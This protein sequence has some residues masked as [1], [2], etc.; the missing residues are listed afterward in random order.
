MMRLKDIFGRTL[1][2]AFSF[3]K[4]TESTS[5]QNSTEF[6]TDLVA[7]LRAR[8]DKLGL[9]KRA[10]LFFVKKIEVPNSTHLTVECDR[11]NE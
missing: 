5:P 9:S 7:Q 10:G 1:K 11:A 8:F 4:C 6:T 2:T 3:S